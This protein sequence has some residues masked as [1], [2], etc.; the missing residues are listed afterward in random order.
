[1]SR[2]L[3]SLILVAAFIA[4][5]AKK[6]LA[7]SASCP[8][9]LDFEMGDFTNWVCKAG[10]VMNGGILNLFVTGPL[11]TRHEIISAA[12][13]GVD[14]YG[15]FPTLC[16][17][18]SHYSVKLGNHATGSQAESIS[19]TYTIPATVTTFSML[20]YYAVVLES[21][22]HTLVNQP[23]FQAR[24]IDVL[25]N[26]PIN[27]VNFDFIPGTTPG[28]FQT[29]PLAG[30]LNSPVL[31]KDWTPISIN[32]SAYIGKTIT[33][34]FITR[35][36]AQNGHAGYAYVDVSSI[37]N[38]LIDG[39]NV[40]ANAT[41]VHLTAPYGFQGYQWYADNT[42]TTPLA[43][44]QVLNLATVPP[45]GTTFP[46]I[47]TPYAGFG[48]VDTVYAVINI[49]PDP[50][51]DAGPDASV[52]KNQ[53]IQIGAPP[54]PGLNYS[55]T[56]ASQVSD[57]A[58]ANPFA[59]VTS[60]SPTQFIVITTD[61]VSGCTSTDTTYITGN[62]V[63]TTMT[64]AGKSSYCSG[65][66]S[67][68]T[69]T[70]TG[71]LSSVQWYDGATPIA[72]ATATSY[73]PVAN[74]NYWAQVGHAG[75]LDSTRTVSFTVNPTPVAN[76]GPDANI[77]VNQPIQI[78]APPVGGVNYAWTPAA[79]VSDPTLSNPLALINNTTPVQFIVIATD[80]V[81]GCNSTDTTIVTGRL[82][83][84]SMSVTGKNNYCIGDPAAGTLILHGA[85]TPIQWYDASGPIAGAT[86]TSYHP[87]TSGT[88]W[89]Q[90]QAFGCTDSSASVIF[91]V[92]AI[93]VPAFS[94]NS[95][96]GCIT[97]HSFVFTNNSNVSDGSTLNYL[98]L[99]S[100]G[101]IQNTSA[102]TKSFLTPGNYTVKL[103]TTSSF[104]CKDST[105]LHVLHVL[106]NGKADFKWDSLCANRPTLFYNLSNERGS[107]QV[108]YNWNFNNGGPGNN[109]K[110]PP[111]VSFPTPGSVDV[112]LKLTA[113][114]CENYPD[115][116]IKKVVVNQ[117][118]PGTTYT[119]IT[120]P[121]GSTK[122]IHAR[123]SVGTYFQ[124]TPL[125][126]LSNY[127]ERYTEFRGLDDITYQIRISD[128]HTCVTVDTVTILILKKPGFY[129]PTAFTPNGDGLN[130][131][132]RPYLVGMKGLKSFSIFNRWGDQL[133][134]TKTYGAGWNGK[135]NGELQ[136]NGVYVWVLEF[137]DGNGK[138]RM[139]KG[140][141]TL[142]R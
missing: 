109:F 139:E 64:V 93:P 16:P 24:I 112:I 104:G 122:F 105:G 29:S 110:N 88:Y 5:P 63:D 83:D 74:G 40:C 98:W 57:P 52:C 43:N 68:G 47:L 106:P 61:P 72:G 116:I 142:I 32:L 85:V 73:H 114:G 41:S 35:D 77:C 120:V 81:S 4:M 6:T 115:S 92:N 95:D 38:G 121:E 26:T 45:I 62:A 130:D 113:L 118:K 13:A 84:T 132:A 119:S 49:A 46:C 99:F 96:S 22:G 31:Y 103:I 25:T 82:V 36:C 135:F 126:S 48:C 117:N 125:Q 11:P 90:V 8:S 55:W 67:A 86:S 79:Q 123:D 2:R 3:L 30:N 53:S 33:L 70:V 75:C 71:S 42:F 80:V 87:T 19:Y 128:I 127:N 65:D 51:S 89:A 137:Y 9:N 56:P 12:T 131:I 15:N 54:N 129:L 136:N 7:Q 76:A 1:M 102:P 18:G 27:C 101:T 20:F 141:I 39:V 134:F 69:L 34:E 107:T 23:R 111:P 37:C 50:H 10:N 28:G 138:L 97:N 124:W 91:N 44:S 17:N 78:G 100:D 60:S 133:F 21:P 58:I 14:P 66:P 108:N 94:V 140:T 59:T